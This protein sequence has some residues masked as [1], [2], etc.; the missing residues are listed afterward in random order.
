MEWWCR[1]LLLRWGGKWPAANKTVS[2]ALAIQPT[3]LVPRLWLLLLSGRYGNWEALTFLVNN[4]GIASIYDYHFEDYWLAIAVRVASRLTTVKSVPWKPIWTPPP[5]ILPRWWCR[6]WRCTAT[7]PATRS[8]RLWPIWPANE[9]YKYLCLGGQHLQLFH[10]DVNDAFGIKLVTLN[11]LE[12]PSGLV[13]LILNHN[14][15]V[16]SQYHACGR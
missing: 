5:A 3:A 8:H 10:L 11:S 2:E 13:L 6:S 4:A 1:L 16:L 9:A 15:Q 7:V 12:A 14:V